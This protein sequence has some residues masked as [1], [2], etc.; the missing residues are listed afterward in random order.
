[1]EKHQSEWVLKPKGWYFYTNIVLGLLVFPGMFVGSFFILYYYPNLWYWCIFLLVISGFTLVIGIREIIV[2]RIRITSTEVLLPEGRLMFLLIKIK[3]LRVGLKDLH[4]MYVSGGIDH[5]GF[6][7]RL[8]FCYEDVSQQVIE[9]LRFSDY[10]LCDIIDKIKENAEALNGK[11]VILE[12][13]RM[14]KGF[15]RKNRDDPKS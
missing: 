2:Y 7:E 13:D 3:W 14:Q 5:D 11:Q 8:H 6:Y 4:A 10:Q 9:V 1:M 12:E 15:R